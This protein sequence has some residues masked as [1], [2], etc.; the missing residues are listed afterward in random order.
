MQWK[1]IFRQGILTAG[2]LLWI[3]VMGPEIYVD[4]GAGCLV[5]ADGNALTREETEQLLDKWFYHSEEKGEL[6][7]EITYRSKLLEWLNQQ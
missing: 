2:I 6:Q 3:S 5:D 1:K 7:Y 4:T